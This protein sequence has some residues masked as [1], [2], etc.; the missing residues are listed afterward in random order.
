M[1]FALDFADLDAAGHVAGVCY[2]NISVLVAISV[3][4]YVNCIE[5]YLNEK[6]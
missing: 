3:A 4:E 6:P 1:R 5:R 2:R